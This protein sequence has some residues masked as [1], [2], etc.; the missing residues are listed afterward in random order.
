MKLLNLYILK[1]LF[2]IFLIVIPVF[3]FVSI[4]IQIIEKIKN[5][6]IFD[7]LNFLIYLLTSLPEKLYYVIPIA[8]VI[9]FFIVYRELI[10]SKKIYPIFLNGISIKDLILP[11]ILF[12]FIVFT[13]QIIN[14][15][16]VM[17]K[18]DEISQKYYKKLKGANEDKEEKYLF[19]SNQWIKLDNFT[20]AYFGFLDLNSYM[21]RN[22][23]YLKLDNTSFYPLFR[24]EAK[25]VKI[26][27]YNLKLEEGRVISLREI[28]NF[29]YINFKKLDYPVKIDTKN[30]RKLIKIKRAVSI[31][32]FYEK[33]KIA[34]KFG[35]PSAFFWSRFFSYLTT[36]FS[37]IVL[38]I[39]IYPLI[40][41]KR[42]EKYFIIFGSIFIYWYVVPLIASLSESG[43]VPYFSPVILDF[44][45]LTAGLILLS[46]IKF[47]EL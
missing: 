45:Y 18:S 47:V 24:L 2:I 40:W 42:R 27:K 39:F 41:L 8:A 10:L 19:I 38:I 14:N 11:A 13:V 29:D 5:I 1:K 4:L 35:Y 26:K 23:I 16:I 7:P 31:T 21:G 20:F 37:P 3:S 33:A 43:A 34:D 9:S 30:L 17:P 6:K 12:S 46:K 32:Q 15:I 25:K 22:F 44:I 36:L 28:K